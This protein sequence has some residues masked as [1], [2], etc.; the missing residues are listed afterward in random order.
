MSNGK[1]GFL[2][3]MNKPVA[4]EIKYYRDNVFNFSVVVGH[5]RTYPVRRPRANS[6]QFVCLTKG[7]SAAF[8]TT[9]IT[10]GSHPPFHP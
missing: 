9:L 4:C 5:T 7:T 8:R 1:Y 3:T 10:V 2:T 6:S